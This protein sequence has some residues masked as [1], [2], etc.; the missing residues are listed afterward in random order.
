MARSLKN[1]QITKQKQKPKKKDNELPES[2]RNG[3]FQRL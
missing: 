2:Y 1:K 3:Q